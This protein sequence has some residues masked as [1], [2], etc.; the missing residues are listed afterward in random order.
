MEQNA[1]TTTANKKFQNT[2]LQSL[3]VA[4]WKLDIKHK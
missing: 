1:M 3:F 4:N 2:F